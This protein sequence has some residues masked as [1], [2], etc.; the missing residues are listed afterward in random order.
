MFLLTV[1]LSRV[2]LLH[3]VTF[4]LIEN[5]IVLDE[6]LKNREVKNEESDGLDL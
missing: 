6:M 4:L 1:T 2:M 5:I 3:I